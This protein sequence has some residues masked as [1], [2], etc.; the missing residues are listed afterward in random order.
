[1][2]SEWR[3]QICAFL[4]SGMVA[5]EGPGGLPAIAAE[6]VIFAAGTRVI[7]RC[8]RPALGLAWPDPRVQEEA[9]DVKL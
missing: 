2:R 5:A 7:V 9:S 6:Y 1:M 4:M 3:F 8:G